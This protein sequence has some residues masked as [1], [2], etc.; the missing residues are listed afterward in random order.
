MHDQVLE[1]LQKEMKFFSA[2]TDM[3]SSCTI[4][5]YLSL[6]IHYIS[7]SWELVSYCLQ[8][9]FM[10]EQ[11]TGEKLELA[12]TSTLQEWDLDKKQ[13]VNITTDNGSNI[14]LV[15]TLLG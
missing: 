6:T 14:K 8:V 2:T 5:P 11:H 3:W 10:P 1:D 13:I 7:S 9:H 12:L 15:C 4:D